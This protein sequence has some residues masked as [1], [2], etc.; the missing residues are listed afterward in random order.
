MS[1]GAVYGYNPKKI[2]ISEN[3]KILLKNIKKLSKAKMFY[4][5]NKLNSEKLFLSLNNKKQSL[6]PCLT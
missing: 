2:K 3:H 5:L 6:K 1:S 4:A